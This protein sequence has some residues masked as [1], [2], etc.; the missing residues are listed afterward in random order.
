VFRTGIIS[1]QKTNR[2][3]FSIKSKIVAFKKTKTRM[4]SIHTN[5]KCACD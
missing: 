5:L 2:S 3:V 1:F 4:V